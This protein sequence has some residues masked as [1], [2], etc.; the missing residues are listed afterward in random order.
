MNDIDRSIDSMDFAMRRRFAW[1]EISSV[2]RVEM[3]NDLK[4]LKD[5]A[6]QKMKSLNNAIENTTG[7]NPSYHIGPAYFRKL[8]LYK[9]SDTMWNDLWEFHIKGLLYE[10]IRGTEDIPD[11]ME[12]FEQAYMNA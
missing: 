12:T 1:R 6:V 9:D 5:K 10:Y 7:L 11:K 2:E 3:L 8:L 4:N